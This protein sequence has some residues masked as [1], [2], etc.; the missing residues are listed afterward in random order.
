MPPDSNFFLER[1]ETE[2]NVESATMGLISSV[3]NCRNNFTGC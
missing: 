1:L 3:I 2:G